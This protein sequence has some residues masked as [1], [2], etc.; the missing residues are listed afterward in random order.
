MWFAK[1]RTVGCDCT[2]VFMSL[3]LSSHASSQR[4]TV[5]W[6]AVNIDRLGLGGSAGGLFMGWWV[7]S[8][9]DWCMGQRNTA[10]DVCTAPGG[11]ALILALHVSCAR[12]RASFNHVVCRAVACS[13]T[14]SGRI[15]CSL[16]TV[17]CQ[18]FAAQHVC[19]WWG[20]LHRDCI[21]IFIYCNALHCIEWGLFAIAVHNVRCVKK[22]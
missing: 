11:G 18:A 17:A 13:S 6:V 14:S 4:L 10:L 1:A 9:A 22:F 12:C 7:V 21:G 16:L 15:V 20:M 5:G 2:G 19:C 3:F 8:T